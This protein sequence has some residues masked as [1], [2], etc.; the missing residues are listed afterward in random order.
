VPV[1]I[2]SVAPH[3]GYVTQILAVVKLIN[4]TQNVVG[5]GVAYTV[6][7]SFYCFSFWIF[8]LQFCK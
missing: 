2:F 4:P 5:E 8:R 7:A 6:L 1:I 3:V